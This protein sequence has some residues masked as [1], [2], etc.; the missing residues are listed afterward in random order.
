MQ[1]IIFL[2]T[3]SLGCA[4]CSANKEIRLGNE[5]AKQCDENIAGN[6]ADLAMRKYRYSVET[7]DRSITELDSVFLV[8]YMPTDTIMRGGGGE[9]KISKETCELLDVKFYQ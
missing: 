1:T 9:L 7:L 4:G 8:Q 5:Q 3:L 6:S 2:T